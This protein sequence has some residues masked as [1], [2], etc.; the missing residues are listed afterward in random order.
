MP[1]AENLVHAVYAL[2]RAGERE[3][4]LQTYCDACAAFGNDD[5]GRA[6]CLRHIGDLAAELGHCGDARTALKEAEELY[7]G[8]IDD[9]LALANTLRLLA[10]LDDDKSIWAE[11]RVVYLRAALVTGLDLRAA[12][13]ECDRHLEQQPEP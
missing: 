3:R 8:S 1:E 9:T 11:A 4:A 10:L 5:A 13:N 7:R 2:R 12:I 6:H